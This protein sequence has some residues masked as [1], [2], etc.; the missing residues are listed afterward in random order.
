MNEA[1]KG[2]TRKK[3]GLRE[4]FSKEG[5]DAYY[6]SPNTPLFMD[7]AEATVW[8]SLLFVVIC[9]VV[10][11]RSIIEGIVGG[12]G[13]A[14]CDCLVIVLV[15]LLCIPGSL[16]ASFLKLDWCDKEPK[17]MTVADS[18]EHLGI[19]LALVTLA[20]VIIAGFCAGVIPG[21][22][23]LCM[24]FSKFDNLR[25][26]FKYQ[27]GFG[28]GFFFYA[29]LLLSF[30]F[31]FSSQPNYK[32]E[33]YCWFLLAVI[34]AIA[35]IAPFYNKNI[36]SASKFF[37]IIATL[38]FILLKRHL[39]KELVDDYNGVD[40][41]NQA[42]VQLT[43]VMA[44]ADAI[45]V[46]SDLSLP[47]EAVVPDDSSV[48]FNDTPVVDSFV[49]T[50]SVEDFKD[51]RFYNENMEVEYSIQSTGTPGEYNITD[52][53]G[54]TQGTIVKDGT[55]GNAT[56]KSFGGAQIEKIDGNGFIFDEGGNNVGQIVS[57]GAGNTIVKDQ[58]GHIV[59]QALGGISRDEDNKINGFLQKA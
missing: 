14:I 26:I 38:G 55:S 49:G 1:K 9:N 39:Y 15:F 35:I 2:A 40:N 11:S 13:Y 42:G 31:V 36:K 18:R 34:G 46:P 28:H 12:I 8:I 23:L 50:G 20:S 17:D 6:L 32:M 59:M 19:C 57:D 44:G 47:T 22:I 43:S 7:I 16:C 41:S 33:M 52:E 45:S 27:P 24:L 4:L 37:W 30:L 29:M 58:D 53:N 21:L 48:M 3:K 56:I 54:I 5:Y 25:T 51:M 10:K